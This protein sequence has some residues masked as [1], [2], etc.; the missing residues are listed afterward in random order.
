[1]TR[2]IG[3][4]A[5]DIDGTILHHDGK[6]DYDDPESLAQAKADPFVCQRIARLM[7][8]GLDIHFVTGRS[9]AVRPATLAQ[10]RALV[11]PDVSSVN[12]HTQAE[13]VGYDAMCQWKG[14]TLKSLGAQWFVGDHPADEEAARL[15]GIPFQ[16]A[17]EYSRTCQI[18]VQQRERLVLA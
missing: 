4:G 17:N 6:P 2:P 13:F 15:A 10:L 3:I 7:E 16:Y 1:M 8:A 14:F 5:F 11:S 9:H 12:L 18:A